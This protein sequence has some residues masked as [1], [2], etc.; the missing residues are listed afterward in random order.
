M[1]GVGVF[2]D[3]GFKILKLEFKLCGGADTPRSRDL[4]DTY[5]GYNILDI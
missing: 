2:V 1:Y 4:N 3:F 5:G